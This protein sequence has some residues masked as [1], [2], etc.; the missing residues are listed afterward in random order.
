M[1]Y[2]DSPIT[3]SSMT[4]RDLKHLIQMGEGTYL[5]FKKRTPDAK[6]IAREMAAFANTAGGTILVGVAD[7]GVVTGVQAYFEEEY[8]LEKAAYQVCVP[9]LKIS[10][11]LVHAIEGDVMVVRVP[12]AEMKPVYLK[13]KKRRQV[14]VR[15]DDESTLA[16]EEMVDILKN[17][18]T[19]EGVTFEYGDNE[20]KLFRFLNEYGEITVQKYAH[21]I[22]VT[23]WR[24]S[25]ILVNLVNAGILNLSNRDNVDYFT[26]SQ[27][28]K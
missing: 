23:T 10:I 9:P 20:Q 16:S 2:Q 6:K 18:T 27:R 4:P 1:K 5:E 11:E 12:E 17:E 14:F 3:V 13:G 7:D 24:S 25:R 26:F 15:R 8:L 22:N 28:T 19:E 21:L